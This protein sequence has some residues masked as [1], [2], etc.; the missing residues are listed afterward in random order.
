MRTQRLPVRWQTLNCQNERACWRAIA[1]S[2][3]PAANSYQLAADIR[4]W[5]QAAIPWSDA[6]GSSHTYTNTALAVCLAR[7]SRVTLHISSGSFS[8]RQWL[9]AKAQINNHFQ[10]VCRRTPH[11]SCLMPC[12]PCHSTTKC[13]LM[14]GVIHA[15][16]TVDQL[17]VWW[18][19]NTTTTTLPISLH[20]SAMASAIIVRAML[21]NS[22]NVW[23]SECI[24]WL[25]FAACSQILALAS[26][27]LWHRRSFI[28]L[29]TT[30]CTWHF[31][32]Y[33]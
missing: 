23:S 3:Q 4:C 18:N 15:F 8:W 5:W 16:I 7:I 22:K 24:T 11:A 26:A 9:T 6:S 25:P 29:T 28:M 33:R 30:A 19:N 17:N 10:S 27:G 1:D 21:H 12:P 14:F 32:N 20:H 2:C 31:V 13:S